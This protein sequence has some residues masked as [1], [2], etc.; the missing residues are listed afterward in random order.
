[1]AFEDIAEIV[2]VA[3]ARGLGDA[4]GLLVRLPEKPGRLVHADFC[5][6]SRE[7]HPHLPLK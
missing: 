5:H 6:I 1:M 3:E 7:G 2:G 4:V